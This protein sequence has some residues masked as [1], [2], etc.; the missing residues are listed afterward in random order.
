MPEPSRNRRECYTSRTE[1]KMYAGVLRSDPAIKSRLACESTG[2]IPGSV[3]TSLRSAPSQS[4][5]WS[6]DRSQTGADTASS[7]VQ[8]DSQGV[9][10]SLA[11]AP[12]P[13]PQS[14]E[15]RA[16]SAGTAAMQRQTPD[17]AK[18]HAISTAVTSLVRTAS[19]LGES[20]G[21]SSAGESGGHNQSLPE[22]R[23]LRQGLGELWGTC[24][25]SRVR[26]FHRLVAAPP[27]AGVPP[28]QQS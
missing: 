20:V 5:A 17:T 7:A 3:A 18:S 16:G 4:M 21:L 24:R 25:N 23:L 26:S 10:S 1:C 14:W 13:L 9:P 22:L 11:G 15:S 19:S 2:F 27:C 12:G 28:A 6:G 8:S